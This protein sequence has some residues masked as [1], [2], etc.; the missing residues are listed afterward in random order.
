MS[1]SSG[2]TDRPGVDAGAGARVDA[3][4][5]APAPAAGRPAPAALDLPG[6]TDALERYWAS[7]WRL[8]GGGAAGLCSAVFCAVFVIGWSMIPTLGGLGVALLV[9]GA[10]VRHRARRM[11]RVLGAGPWVAHTSVAL[12]RGSGRAVVV[13][14]GP[15]PSEL[16]PLAPSTVQWRLQ[17]L[18]GPGGVLW[19]CGD[20]RKGGVLAPPGGTELIWARPVRGR[21]ARSIA[22]RPQASALH[23]RPAPSQPQIAP[24]DAAVVGAPVAETAPVAKVA[25]AAPVAKV[26][27]AAP[28]AEVRRRPWWRGI[29][30]WVFV[31]GCLLVALAT[32]WS[33]ASDGDP[34][35]DL[36]V[37]GERGDGR[38]VVRWTDPYGGKKR[39]GLF[40]CAP[41][42]ASVEGY[43]NGYVVSYPPFKGDLYD[44]QLRGT[45]AF[46][47]T[48][49]VGLGGLALVAFGGVGGVV[50]LVVRGRG[51]RGRRLPPHPLPDRPWVRTGPGAG[52]DDRPGTESARPA[53]A[54]Y[55]AFAAVADR[56]AGLR[57][58]DPV[59]PRAVGEVRSG[60]KVIW[61]RVP[62]LRY[63]AG[64]AETLWLL[65]FA[66][67]V[68]VL[69]W[70]LG[71]NMVPELP[72]GLAVL[73]GALGLYFAWR[74]I[75]S[76]IPLAR[77]MARAVVAPE[78]RTL[79]YAL[80][81]DVSSATA[82]PVLVL[83]PI[84]GAAGDTGDGAGEEAA[85]NVDD[86][87]PEG[88]LRLLPPGPYTY[89]WAGLPAPT[90]IAELRGRRDGQPLVVAWIEGRPYWPQGLY[91]DIDP[92]DPGAV[93][94]LADLVP[95]P[96]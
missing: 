71:A 28:V 93:D 3:E 47:V 63:V 84:E 49:A 22:A 58:P 51:S 76:G 14:S 8:F 53:P 74:T 31:V 69:C 32:W 68:A 81:H 27:E 87:P 50:R 11:R 95:G 48:D 77:R 85:E 88:L 26:A 25:E 40:H 72:R 94:A 19:W 1:D 5:V 12:Q 83:F 35:V 4:A 46:A 67:A 21:R 44:A 15:G 39:T 37:I 7:A 96:V 45:Q 42:R 36:T 62:M 56:Q 23:T 73:S 57:G 52:P 89:P 17:L 75:S 6:T 91:E 92:S 82:G 80:L 78:T 66:S 90:G 54:T 20:P 55:T 70:V 43:E 2:D 38:C 10:V 13:L 60:Q 34:R 18:N 61:W 65:G 30:R 24:G 59:E 9:G 16:L 86:P 41:Y 29:F 33:V 64:T 79:R